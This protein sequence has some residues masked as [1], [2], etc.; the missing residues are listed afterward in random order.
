MRTL[1]AASV[2]AL[3]LLVPTAAAH[4]QGNGSIPTSGSIDF[5][6]GLKRQEGDLARFANA[7]SNPESA[8]YRQYLGVREISRRFGA[9]PVTKQSVKRFFAKHGAVARIDASG[10]FAEVSL[11][12]SQ[13]RS[14]F[15]VAARSAANDDTPPP[16]PAGLEGLVTGV[17]VPAASPPPQPAATLPPGIRLSRTGSSKGCPEG[18]NA[19]ADPKLPSVSFTPNQIAQAHGLGDMH[20]R[21]LQGQGHRIALLEF[22]GGFNPTDISTFATCF[23][24]PQP[25]VRV[26]SIDVSAP[27]PATTKSS[28]EVTLDIEVI[29]GMAPKLDSIDVFEGTEGASFAQGFAAALE[30]HKG[31]TRPDAI[32]VSYGRCELAEINLASRSQRRLDRYM[33]DVGVAAGVGIFVSSDDQGSSAC[34]NFAD[35]E[36]DKFALTSY[37]ATQ[38]HVT[39]VGGMSFVLRKDNSILQQRVWNDLVLGLDVDPE[40]GA[41]GGGTSQLIGR[42]DYQ[43]DAGLRKGKGRM[44]PDL[45]FYA[46]PVPGWAIYCTATACGNRGWMAV[47]GTSAATPLFASGVALANQEAA[48]AGQPPVGFPNPLLYQLARTKASPFRDIVLGTNDLFSTGCCHAHKGYD[49]ASGWGSMDLSDF[50]HQAGLAY[51]TRGQ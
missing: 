43:R 1:L 35:P 37:P 11:A 51:R 47:G 7:V 14:V 13:V 10:A 49:R 42:P 4:A 16:V 39:A 40:P 32:S 21:G 44:V 33:I 38:Q 8:H 24:L 2:A 45:A 9:N 30:P 12:P 25:N 23:G 20:R 6:L 50:S 3:S 22:G 28:D 5:L 26:R 17:T 27:L 18:Q 46:D 31:Q 19:Q 29:A 48:K 34:K 41:G 36:L 15:G